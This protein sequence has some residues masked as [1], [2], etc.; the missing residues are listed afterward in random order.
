MARLLLAI[1]VFVALVQIAPANAAS[2][3]GDDVL[4]LLYEAAPGE[5]N[6]VRVS[7]SAGAYTVHDSGA[8]L[9]P[10]NASCVTVNPNE[11]RC[12]SLGL[13]WRYVDVRLGDG[14]DRATIVSV[15]R[16]DFPS[17]N[18]HGEA[19]NDA[20]V[21][22]DASGSMWGGEGDD[23]LELA[24]FTA[25]AFFFGDAGD[26]F[27]RG[28]SY[29]DDF[30]G[31]EGDDTV[32]YSVYDRLSG[33]PGRDTLD[34]SV[35]GQNLRF[36]LA[37]GTAG[38]GLAMIDT[39]FENVRSGAGD[40]V[41][42]GNPSANRFEGGGGDDLFDGAFGPDTLL[43][44][45][46]LDIADFSARTDDV[47]IVLDGTPTSGNDDDGPAGARDAIHSDVE[48]GFGGDGDDV[49][50]GSAV[51][52]LFNGGYGADE[53]SGFGG[54][55]LV[56]YSDRTDAVTV[57]LDGTANSGNADDGP[58]GA[59]DVVGADVE[60]IVSGD[61]DDTLVGNG[62]DNFLDGGF[63][64]DILR[65]GAGNDLADYSWR[66]A[67]LTI[68]LDG[69]ARSGNDDDGPAGARD[70]LESIEDVLGGYQNDAIFGNA[71]DNMLI[72]G[73][74]DDALDGGPG[75]DLL[76]AGADVDRVTSRDGEVDSL[77][78]GEHWDTV[79]VER[80]DVLVDCEVIDQGPA[81]VATTA[82]RDITQTSATLTGVVH[83]N[84]APTG[85]WFEF[86]TTTSYGTRTAAVT[87]P[88][89]NDDVPVTS[90]VRGLVVGTAYH[91]RVVAQNNPGGPTYGADMTFTTANAT[92]VVPPRPP[93]SVRCRVPNVKGKSLA[94]GKRA[95]RRGN[96]NVGKVRRIY[97]RTVA[98]GRIL[99]Q[100]RRPGSRLPK[101]TKV[102]VVFSRG[103]KPQTRPRRR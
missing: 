32:A 28:G 94:A 52:N 17:V 68:L 42:I 29:L 69:T 63:G 31:G 13:P 103:K 96:C 47:T 99:S 100:S 18:L 59:R 44:G 51:G 1:G 62:A 92:V 15:N 12:T 2:V 10:G 43:G 39:T 19:G 64:A 66:N 97:S 61:G 56:D 75:K 22:Q 67:D 81:A 53:F 91:F 84:R 101:G 98:K 54:F 70:A 83:P 5:I 77:L 45:D 71:A 48:G 21:F 95:L 3:H 20:A 35:L 46:G 50:V 41:L 6:D 74:G 27:F 82:A 85:V 40:D 16:A 57:I 93:A 36:D 58:N 33:G 26:D 89:G 76:D 87:L 24:Q 30:N 80:V 38:P 7:Y 65:G 79:T 72:S 25:T 4:G 102:G 55:D 73:L 11:V 86:G 37:E 34:F 14:N 49:L 9:T 8:T 90:A 23:R 78:C 88:G 60:D